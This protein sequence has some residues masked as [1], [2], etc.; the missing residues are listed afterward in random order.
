M[1]ILAHFSAILSF[2]IAT[3]IACC[4]PLPSNSSSL[5][6]SDELLWLTIRGK[7]VE[8]VPGEDEKGSREPDEDGFIENAL[9][10]F[11]CYVVNIQILY[12]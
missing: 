1:I 12:L 7:K 11:M 10:N 4:R 9:M 8:V 6:A 2:L 5:I 3:G